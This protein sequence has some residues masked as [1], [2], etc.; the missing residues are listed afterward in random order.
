M[1]LLNKSELIIATLSLM[2]KVHGAQERVFYGHHGNTLQYIR[3]TL[4][5]DVCVRRKKRS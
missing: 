3:F 4:V 5:C 1:H 2:F